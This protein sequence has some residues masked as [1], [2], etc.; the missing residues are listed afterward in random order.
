MKQVTKGRTLRFFQ[1]NRS[2]STPE[3]SNS[4][5]QTDPR[6]TPA[7]QYDQTMQLHSQPHLCRAKSR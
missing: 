1:A 5:G 3:Q 4:K 7:I 6:P 2:R